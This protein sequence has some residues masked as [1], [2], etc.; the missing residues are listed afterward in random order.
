[1]AYDGPASCRYNK[2]ELPSVSQLCF[3][4]VNHRRSMAPFEVT[5]ALCR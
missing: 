4:V 2:I 3:L 1:M 5:P